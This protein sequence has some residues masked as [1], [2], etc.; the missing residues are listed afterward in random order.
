MHARDNPSFLDEFIKFTLIIYFLLESLII[1]LLLESI[2]QLAKLL[3]VVI[4]K[5]VSESL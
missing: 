4:R 3:H 2:L 1:Q 5:T